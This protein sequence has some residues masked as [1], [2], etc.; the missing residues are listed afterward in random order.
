ML[1]D[2][3]KK[4]KETQ[5]VTLAKLGEITELGADKAVVA[6]LAETVKNIDDMIKSLGNAARERL[7]A[8]AQ[9]EKLYGAVRSGAG[10][11]RQGRRLPR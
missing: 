8:G 11:F 2:R 10:G 4:M 1:K 9:H 5:A 6:A 7:E 3:S